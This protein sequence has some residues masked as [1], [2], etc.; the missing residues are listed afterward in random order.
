MFSSISTTVSGTISKDTGSDAILARPNT[1]ALA[2]AG[3]HAERTMKSPTDC[4]GSSQAVRKLNSHSGCRAVRLAEAF[5]PG[6]GSTLNDGSPPGQGR[7]TTPI[8]CWVR[9]PISLVKA[10]R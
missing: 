3:S 5:Q 9:G 1:H 7:R 4:P 10:Y 8:G 2:C 6:A